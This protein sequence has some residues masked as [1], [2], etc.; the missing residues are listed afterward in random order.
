MVGFEPV[1]NIKVLLLMLLKVWIREEEL[2]V[3][4]GVRL[5]VWG[6]FGCCRSEL[7]KDWCEP[8]VR[9]CYQWCPISVHG[10]VASW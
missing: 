2:L 10:L 7:K 4:F 3:V 6:S 9:G 5:L 8:C 1:R